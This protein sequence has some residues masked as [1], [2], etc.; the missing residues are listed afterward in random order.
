MTNEFY[1]SDYDL[2]H[3]MTGR[4]LGSDASG[5]KGT[6]EG[7]DAPGDPRR[8]ARPVPRTRVRL[9]HRGPDRGVGR[10]LPADVLPLLHQQGRS[11]ALVPRP[12]RG[13]H[14]GDPAEPPRR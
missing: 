5:S 9:D 2:W 10:D 13:D 1:L 14:A 3:T 7:E 6:Q 8:R 4:F 12:G 11:R